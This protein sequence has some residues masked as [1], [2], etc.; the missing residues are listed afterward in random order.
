MSRKSIAIAVINTYI[1]FSQYDSVTFNWD[2]FP[3]IYFYFYADFV[4][5]MW[6]AV[7]KRDKKALKREKQIRRLQY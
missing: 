6:T 4:Q 7:C 2:P 3:I 5:W 1:S